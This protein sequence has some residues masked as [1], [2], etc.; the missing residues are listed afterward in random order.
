MTLET[1]PGR[2]ARVVLALPR[3]SEE[4]RQALRMEGFTSSAVLTV[5]DAFRHVVQLG[6]DALVISTRFP[7][8]SPQVVQEMRSARP[9]LRVLVLA[10]EGEVERALMAGDVAI[11]EDE[12]PGEVVGTLGRLLGRAS[13]VA[14]P[15]PPPGWE[16][17]PEG[18]G[19]DGKARI[20]AV[21]GVKGGVGKTTLAIAL[22]DVLQE[23][24]QETALASLDPDG[25][26]L[27]AYL[28]LD[29]R[30]GAAV[31]MSGEE[32]AL[33]GALDRACARLGRLLVLPG[34]EMGEG[35]MSISGNWTYGLLQAL[36]RRAETVVLDLGDLPARTDGQRVS[37]QVAHVVLVV[38]TA[39]VV[40]LHRARSYLPDLRRLRAERW[41]GG[42]V[43]S[44]TGGPEAYSRKE[45]EM[46]MGALVVAEVPDDPMAAK[47]ALARQVP[48]T[49]VGGKAARAVRKLA[50]QL[51]SQ[52]VSGLMAM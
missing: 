39:D 17:G 52:R 40:A 31:L 32:S 51:V 35:W 3:L 42:L 19:E 9:D 25:D 38:T 34:L 12:P 47:R 44:R 1:S 11:A 50:E 43:L 15:P 48:L 6:A 29:P 24:G 33:D 21:T 13:E 14:E 46:A 36:R 26:D 30:L 49:R 22:A 18:E 27:R 37:L 2:P 7:G 5:E 23:R 10:P 8:F 28:H 45:I 20:V 4:L 16:E 41:P